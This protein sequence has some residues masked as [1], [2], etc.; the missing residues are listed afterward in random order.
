MGISQCITL[1]P[2]RL[3]G[4]GVLIQ[5]EHRLAATLPTLEDA[6]RY[7]AKIEREES[8]NASQDNH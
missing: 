3:D 6:L 1:S 2:A 4:D 5:F 7:V 8:Q